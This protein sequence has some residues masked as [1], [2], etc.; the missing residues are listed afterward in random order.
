MGRQGIYLS[1]Y[2]CVC[3]VVAYLA[4][5][6]I[7]G[8]TPAHHTQA[9]CQRAGVYDVASDAFQAAWGRDHMALADID[10]AVARCRNS[11]GGDWMPCWDMEVMM[12]IRVLDVAQAIEKPV[13]NP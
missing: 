1:I 2:S 9:T 7:S 5:L 8:L 6:S 11:E 13:S 3:L 12:L 4:S 10:V